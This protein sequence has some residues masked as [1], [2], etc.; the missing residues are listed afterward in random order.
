MAGV[1]IAK[2][3]VDTFQQV[4]MR[5]GKLNAA[6]FK[7]VDESSIQVE[8][9]WQQITWESFV[10]QFAEDNVAYALFN[11]QFQSKS[12]KVMR[13]KTLLIHWAPK[14]A[15]LKE[16]MMVTMY[17]AKLV[18]TLGSGFVKIQACGKEDLEA[19]SVQE[20]ISS[21]MTVK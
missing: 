12:D 20:K 13:S 1:E 19:S 6:M 7:I 15:S 18:A 11:F 3:C 9:T 16:K 14:T 4:K 8:K 17:K 5:S 2:E 10:Q 21:T